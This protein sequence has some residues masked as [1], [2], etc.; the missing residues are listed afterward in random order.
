MEDGRANCSGQYIG[1]GLLYVTTRHPLSTLWI[2]HCNVIRPHRSTSCMRPI[3]TDGVVLSVRLSVCHDREPC[4]ATEPIVTP[5][6]MLTRVGPRNY[7]LD[8]VQIPTNEQF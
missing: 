7:I 2:V 1:F 6:G 5:F 3:A 8:G 4:K